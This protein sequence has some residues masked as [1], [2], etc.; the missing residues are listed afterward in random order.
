MPV[1]VEWIKGSKPRQIKC[2]EFFAN[3][4]TGLKASNQ[5]AAFARGICELCS[6]CTEPRT[7]RPML[8]KTE[9]HQVITYGDHAGEENC[10]L[11][12]KELVL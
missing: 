8:N 2:Q 11:L 12:G 6:L 10:D 5:A 9:S 1:K 3:T 4:T 7:L